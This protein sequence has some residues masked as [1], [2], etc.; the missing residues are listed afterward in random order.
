[1]I[2]FTS[3]KGGT[4]KSFLALN[5]S[6]ALSKMG[7]KIL[8]I[9]LDINYANINIMMNVIPQQSLAEYFSG[10]KLF[11]EIITVLNEKLH[12]VF[13]ISGENNI[14][15]IANNL[16]NDISLIKDE[17]DFIILDMSAGLDEKM[18]KVINSCRF[19]LIT[20]TPEPSAIMDA[21]VLVKMLESNYFKGENYVVINKCTDAN[22]GE[23]SF[24]NLSAACKH[25]LNKKLFF[26]GEI[27]YSDAVLRS[28]K[29]QEIFISQFPVSKISDQIKALALFLSNKN[30][31]VNINQ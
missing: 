12:I 24:K 22:E 10:K 14:S 16:I 19:N 9:D 11:K 20:A 3:G 1:M 8:L 5:T 23:V 28:C 6:L 13:G 4:G 7:K 17:Y 26:G 2:S 18:I 31:L 25:F 30:Q 15:K 21:Y 27:D 29:S